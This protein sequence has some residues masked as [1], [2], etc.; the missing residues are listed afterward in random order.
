MRYQGFIFDMDDTLYCEYDYVYSGFKVVSKLIAQSQ[1]KITDNIVYQYLID[2]WKR[3]GRGKVFNKVCEKLGI[4]IDISYLVE[5]YRYHKPTIQ[6][7]DDAKKLLLYLKHK[8]VQTGL[9]TD[10][11]PVA[12][13][14][15][16]KSL[17]LKKW[18]DCIIITGILGEEYYKPSEVPY[19][20]A[21]NSL[22]LEA[23][24]CVYIGDNP[25]KDFITAKKLGI[26]TIRVIR[27]IGDYMHVKLSSEFEADIVVYSLTDIMKMNII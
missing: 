23:K 5:A 18:I 19:K 22:G 15:K 16:I 1:K 11:H 8:K 2:E 6:M 4:D 12:Q 25:Y 27:P 24:Q 21:L 9:I 26:K 14:N 13:Y 3:N 10:G 20:I 17:G 7:Y